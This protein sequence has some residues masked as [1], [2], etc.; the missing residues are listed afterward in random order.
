MAPVAKR[1]TISDAGST[2]SS[3]TGV[4]ADFLGVLDAEQAAH[5]SSAAHPVRSPAGVLAILS[6]IVAAHR[7][8][9]VATTIS[10]VQTWLSPRWRKAYSPPTSSALV[11]DRMR[12]RR[13]AVALDGFAAT[14][15]GRRLQPGGGA[16]EELV[17]EGLAQADRVENLRAAI[18][19]VG[20]DAHLG[21]HLEQA[22][23]IAL[24]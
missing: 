6:G 7:M 12:R 15:S 20:G 16:G 9:Q 8:L 5:A 21:H 13:R 2:W 14:S 23:P 1:L 22:L 24:M 4:R 10:G 17:D 18:G 3:G 19:L 11:R